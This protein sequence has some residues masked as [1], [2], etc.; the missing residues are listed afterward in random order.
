MGNYW[1]I[2]VEFRVLSFRQMLRLF[3]SDTELSITTRQTC[4]VY[5]FK[6][7]ESSVKKKKEL[8]LRR[9]ALEGQATRLVSTTPS[10]TPLREPCW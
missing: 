3:F 6:S 9:F 4:Y 7:L 10:L 1:R 2:N 8:F 5:K